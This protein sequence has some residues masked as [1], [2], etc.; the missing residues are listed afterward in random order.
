MLVR[1]SSCMSVFLWVCVRVFVC[2]PECFLYR[3]FSFLSLY[4][5]VRVFS[6]VCAC[7]C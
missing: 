6:C 7:V 3:V 4:A 2:I 1:M 5:C